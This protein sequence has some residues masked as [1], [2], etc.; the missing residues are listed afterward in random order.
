MILDMNMMIVIGAIVALIFYIRKNNVDLASLIPRDLSSLATQRNLIILAAVAAVGYYLWTQNQSA[1][2]EKF[3]SCGNKYANYDYAAEPENTNAEESFVPEEIPLVTGNYLSSEKH[4][5][6]FDQNTSVSL[7]SLQ[8]TDVPVPNIDY[9]KVTNVDTK[10]GIPVSLSTK[11]L[12]D[13]QGKTDVPIDRKVVE[14]T[15]FGV[16]PYV[17]QAVS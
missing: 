14:N 5:Q 11:Y 6:S 8:T 16:S 4:Q 9:G 12:V 3:G 10:G 15:P 2:V 17:L 7:G 13:V 1:A